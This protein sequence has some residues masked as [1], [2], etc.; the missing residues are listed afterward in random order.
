MSTGINDIHM[1]SSS[2]FTF[3]SN[4]SLS[5]KRRIS[6]SIKISSFNFTTLHFKN[7]DLMHSCM[8]RGG[9]MTSSGLNKGNYFTV[10]FEHTNSV[11]SG[12]SDQIVL[13]SSFIIPRVKNATVLT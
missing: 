9:K 12:Q 11:W 2:L 4:V 1:D 10:D 8:R 5:V 3:G 6:R 13:I 7:I